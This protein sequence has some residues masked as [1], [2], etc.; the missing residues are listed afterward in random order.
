M[1]ALNGDKARFQRLRKAGVHRR[2][3]SRLTLA[4]LRQAARLAPGSTASHPGGGPGQGGGMRLI[5]GGLSAG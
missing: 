1:S 3:R 5:R 2:E 4:A